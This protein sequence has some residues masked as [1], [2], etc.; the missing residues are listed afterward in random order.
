ML[1]INRFN[2]AYVLQVAICHVCQFIKHAIYVCFTFLIVIIDLAIKTFDSE[3]CKEPELMQSHF[4]TK[5]LQ[6]VSIFVKLL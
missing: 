1:S 5:K 4:I 3:K 6:H 2:N